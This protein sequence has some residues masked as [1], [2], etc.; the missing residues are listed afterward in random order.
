MDRIIVFFLIRIS[1]RNAIFLQSHPYA[2]RLR[3][4]PI[5]SFWTDS[6]RTSHPPP[7]VIVRWPHQ[8]V[9]LSHLRHWITYT[10]FTPAVGVTYEYRLEGPPSSSAVLFPGLSQFLP[11]NQL[12]WTLKNLCMDIILVIVCSWTQVSKWNGKLT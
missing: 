1:V 9:P 2:T 8:K 4:R 10:L 3:P 11:L 5:E 6:S 7:P 12:P